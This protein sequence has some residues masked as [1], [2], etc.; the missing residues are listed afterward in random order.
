MT[1]DDA[2]SVVLAVPVIAASLLL[3]L[4]AA[5]LGGIAVLRARAGAAA[6][7]AALAAVTS[8]C[9]TAAE[10]AVRNGGRLIRCGWQGDE[11]EAEVAI[12]A[13]AWLGRL[14]LGPAVH[15]AARA[16]LGSS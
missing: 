16:G 4:G 12:A 9:G 2:G 7:L 14:G 6:D 11:V 5:M 10:I 3:A 1:R 13:P 8:G 15:G